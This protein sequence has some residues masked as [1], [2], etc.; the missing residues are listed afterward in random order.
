[1]RNSLQIRVV[2]TILLAVLLVSGLVYALFSYVLLRQAALTDGS[3]HT[4]LES[5]GLWIAVFSVAAAV[6]VSLATTW[7]I[8]RDLTD[9]LCRL[10]FFSKQVASGHLQEQLEG[11][12][13]CEL[14]DLK[15]DMLSMVRQMRS[16]LGYSQG[17]LDCL[18]ESFP[19]LTLDEQGRITQISERLLKLLDLT[20]IPEDYLGS[21]PGKAFFGDDARE[22]TSTQVLRTLQKV[23]RRADIVTTSGNRRVFVSTAS[24]IFDL[25]RQLR[26]SFTLYFDL[27]T[28]TEREEEISKKNED[29]TRLAQQSMSIADQVD[30]AARQLT[31]LMGQANEDTLAHQDRSAEVVT[32]M[33]QMSASILEVARNAHGAAHRAQET[34]KSAG[35]GASSILHLVNTIESVDNIISRLEGRIGEL[36]IQAENIDQ[37]VNVISDIAD[38][39]NLLAL[40]AAIEAARAGD[41]GRGFAVVAD[42]VRKL[43]EKTMT[44]TKEVGTVIMGIQASSKEAG[45]EMVQA[46][47][48]VRDI[49]EKAG[50][51]G[52][53]LE[54]ILGLVKETD[55]Q[56]HSIATAVEQQS[57]ASEQINRSVAVMNGAATNISEVVR[58]AGTS[59]KTMSSQAEELTRTMRAFQGPGADTPQ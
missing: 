17:I 3:F 24:P 21:T 6:V 16:T 28:L 58:S 44:A 5:N 4:V 51:S 26:G 35:E 8:K 25:D 37:V 49:T 59:V 43:A 39:T 56:V 36:A 42:E 46:S 2:G 10:A 27:T 31:E 19:Y 1:M 47:E 7:F 54:V 30:I 40:N 22:T 50:H 55:N 34:S 13:V 20:G 18:A 52:R 29:I 41:A 57:A 14:S 11:T 15:H 9:P 53:T 33:E 12:F 32:A 23:E 48:A 45:K 38:Q